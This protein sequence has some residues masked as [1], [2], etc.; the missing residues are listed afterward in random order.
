MEKILLIIILPLLTLAQTNIRVKGELVT[1][2]NNEGI[3]ILNEY[4]DSCRIETA[5]T[6]NR[7]TKLNQVSL[8]NIPPLPQVGGLCEK[9]KIY[10]YDTTVVLCLQ[11]HA[12]TIFDPRDTPNLFAIYREG[13]NLEWT[14]NEYVA[15]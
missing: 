11:T 13:T 1:I 4:I 9:N 7:Y 14:V 6:V 3:I 5:Q 10:A 2:K 8:Q 12:R 15:K